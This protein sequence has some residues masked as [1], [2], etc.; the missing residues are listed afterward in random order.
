MLFN[1][2]DGI[3]GSTAKVQTLRALLPLT[4][5][6]SGREAQKLARIKSRKGASTALEDLFDLGVLQRTETRGSH[7]Y[8]VNREHELVRPLA[9]LF[10]EEEGRLQL[11]VSTLRSGLAERN[12]A[13]RVCSVILYGSNAR[14]G[15]TPRSDVDILV[16]VDSDVVASEVKEALYDSGQDLRRR[17]GLRISPYVLTASRVR[18][19]VEDGDTLLAAIQQEGRLLM[20]EPLDR[21]IAVW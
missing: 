6:V 3:L 5:P 15:A 11:L 17:L 12:L 10:G 1:P 9:I 19:R 20:G 4:A 18:E 21:I 13:E 2:L 8:Q 7:L 16:V 14:R